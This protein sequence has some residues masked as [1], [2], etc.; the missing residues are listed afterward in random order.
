MKWLVRNKFNHIDIVCAITGGIFFGTGEYFS[1][2]LTLLIG[3]FVSVLAE[4]YYL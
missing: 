1:L 4:K 2:F 3:S